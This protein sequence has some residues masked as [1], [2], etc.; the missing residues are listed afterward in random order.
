MDTKDTQTNGTPTDD[1][2]TA[3]LLDWIEGSVRRL[4]ASTEGLTEEQLRAPAAPSGW[5]VVGL[6]GHVRDSTTFWLRHVVAGEPFPFD[7][8]D[9]AWDDDPVR[10]ATEVVAEVVAEV[11]GAC[12]AVRGTDSGREPAW[13]PEGAWGGYRQHTV[14]G[15]LLH[16]LN[17][18]AAHTGQL[19]I[20]R[21]LIDGAVWDFGVNGLHCQP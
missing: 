21:E 5:S 2:V 1:P 19:D 16:L 6:L 14:R 7:E 3:E 9:D 13:W 18:N 4:V 17:D 11:V 8:G 20:A 12:R 15:V 10:P